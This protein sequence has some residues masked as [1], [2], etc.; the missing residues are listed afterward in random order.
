M[1]PIT[2]GLTF[3]FNLYVSKWPLSRI[4]PYKI[5]IRMYVTYLGYTWIGIVFY[6]VQTNMKEEE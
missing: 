5:C 2:L 4:G 1:I 3:C 6:E